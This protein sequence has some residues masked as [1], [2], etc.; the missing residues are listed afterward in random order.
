[1]QNEYK[2]EGGYVFEKENRTI[3]KVVNGILFK[4]CIASSRDV[5]KYRIFSLRCLLSIIHQRGFK[6]FHLVPTDM[7]TYSVRFKKMTNKND[8]LFYKLYF[9]N[10]LLETQKRYT[11][12]D[13]LIDKIEKSYSYRHVYTEYDRIFRDIIGINS[14]WFGMLIS[15][16]IHIHSCSDK[17]IS[18]DTIRAAMNDSI[19]RHIADVTESIDISALEYKELNKEKIKQSLGFFPNEIDKDIG[20][21]TAGIPIRDI[22][23]TESSDSTDYKTI[24]SL[25]SSTNIDLEEPCKD[26]TT[27]SS[28]V[29]GNSHGNGHNNA[30]DTV[31]DPCSNDGTAS[32]SAAKTLSEVGASHIDSSKCSSN[33]VIQQPIGKSTEN[34]IKSLMKTVGPLSNVLEETKSNRCKDFEGVMKKKLSEQY[35]LNKEMC[36]GLNFIIKEVTALKTTLYDTQARFM[37]QVQS[38]LQYTQNMCNEMYHSLY[39]Q[40]VYNNDY[41]NMCQNTCQNTCQNVCQNMCHNNFQNVYQNMCQN[42]GEDVHFLPTHCVYQSATDTCQNNTYNNTHK[43]DK[44]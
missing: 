8:L 33:N 39:G 2:S 1:M 12:F 27:N 19:N 26:V 38:Q 44:K 22:I 11:Q 17:M 28:T 18:L 34:I 35:K 21:C 36:D 20:S 40:Y 5:L 4:R 16:E 24:E 10:M 15:L 32:S 31:R 6:I 9:Y 37:N 43:N 30:N 3:K 25:S 29:N 42:I 14:I 7:Y 23:H 13:Y 41:Q